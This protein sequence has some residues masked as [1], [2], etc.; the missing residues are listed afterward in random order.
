MKNVVGSPARGTNFFP[1]QREVDRIVERLQSANNLQIAAPRRVGKTSILYHLLDNDI[2]DFVYV[3]VD[4]ESVDNGQDFFK[5]LLKEILKVK[6]VAQSN[7]L[8]NLMTAGNRFLSRI[9]SIKVAGQGLDFSEPENPDYYEELLHFLS[10]FELEDGR[11]LVLLIDE[12]PQTIL[13]I[14]DASDGD[15]QPAR[16][17][18]QANRELR[19]QWEVN[20]KVRFIY[21]GSIGLNHTVASI[22][23]SAFVNDLSAV[24][25]DALRPAEAATLIHEVLKERGM[26]M[27]QPVID[28][29]LGKIEW[30]IPFH[31]QLALQE[32]S[33]RADRGAAVSQQQ[34][35]E[36]FDHIV[37][38]RN[39][40]HFQHYHHRLKT[41]FKKERYDFVCAVLSEMATNVLLHRNRMFDLSL[42]HGVDGDFRQ[43]I[44]VLVYDGYINNS[45]NTAEYRFNSPIVRHWWERHICH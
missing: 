24:E 31:I 25:V 11:K 7:L 41:Q 2:A 6:A 18:L 13:N 16:R 42:K 3:Y 17:F 22:N 9:K 26:T 33:D 20:E 23:A 34:V 27:T 38:L 44:D 43:I 40:N 15:L 21:T 4:T 37:D 39:D 36:A 32:I 29:L 12:F 30:L 5:K 10:G 8:R 1:R 45:G 14:V 28:H 19:H 35:D